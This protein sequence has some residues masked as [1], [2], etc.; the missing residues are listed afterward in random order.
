MVGKEK[1]NPFPITHIAKE[2]R[3][4]LRAQIGTGWHCIRI[5]FKTGVLHPAEKINAREESPCTSSLAHW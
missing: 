1:S 3:K 2:K 5:T 4:P